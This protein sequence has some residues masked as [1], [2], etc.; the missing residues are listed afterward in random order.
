MVT[1]WLPNPKTRRFCSGKLIR[2]VGSGQRGRWFKSSRPDHSM[3]AANF[4]R[5]VGRLCL[6]G[7]C[8]RWLAIPVPPSKRQ[9]PADRPVPMRV[10]DG[11]KSFVLDQ[12]VDLGDVT[13][14]S[15]FGGVGRYRRGTFFGL[16]AADVLCLKVD[17]T[18]RTEYEHTGMQPFKPY[19]QRPG[20]MQYYSVPLAV[21]ESA[22]ELTQWARKA[23]AAAERSK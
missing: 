15:M 10:S 16:M 4:L 6:W 8:L 3:K 17:A 19:P 18:T 5:E 23:V 22:P 9:R 12:L 2:L 21:V 11:F 13:A 1:L 14:P 20:T 7:C